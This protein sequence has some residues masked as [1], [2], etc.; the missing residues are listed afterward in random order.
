MPKT[1]V[2]LFRNR[3]VVDEVVR[4]IESVGFPRNEIRTLGEPLDLGVAGVMSV[5][6]IDF[7]VD[8]FRELTKMGAA[9]AIS[10]TG[11]PKARARPSSTQQQVHTIGRSAMRALPPLSPASKPAGIRSR[12]RPTV[13][14]CSH[15]RRSPR[16]FAGN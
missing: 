16:W 11:S 10:L 7:E 2:G 5:S 8:L 15:P 6:R 14:N 4:E 13:R 3:S 9:I 1:A 12:H